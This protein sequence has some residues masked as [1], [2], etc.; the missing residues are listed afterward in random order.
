MHTV[1]LGHAAEQGAGGQLNLR[2]LFDEGIYP[3]RSFPGL[4]PNH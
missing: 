2:T 1:T 3:G 4:S